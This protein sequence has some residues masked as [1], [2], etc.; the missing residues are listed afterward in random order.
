MNS[1]WSTKHYLQGRTSSGP[2]QW[3]VRVMWPASASA[4]PLRPQCGRLHRSAVDFAPQGHDGRHH[5]GLPPSQRHV[6][7]TPAA[8]DAG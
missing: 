8:L 6:V 1:L 5:D 3:T 4:L 7:L 2:R